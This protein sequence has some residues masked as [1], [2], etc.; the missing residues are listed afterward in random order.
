MLLKKSYELLLCSATNTYVM[1]IWSDRI[2]SHFSHIK[3]FPQKKYEQN[4]WF[5][6]RI[7]STVL[8]MSSVKRVCLRVS[9]SSA[10]TTVLWFIPILSKIY[11]W[12]RSVNIL[13]ENH[14]SMTNIIFLQK[15]NAKAYNKKCFFAKVTKD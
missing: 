10:E 7:S 4:L 8:G 1:K 14:F 13:P 15:T 12:G 2:I 11:F 6:F 3:A 5:F 9:E